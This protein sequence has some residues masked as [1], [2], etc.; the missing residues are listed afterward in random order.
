MSA[1]SPNSLESPPASPSPSPPL[2][3]AP[4][5]R[6]IDHEL[7]S[8]TVPRHVIE[9]FERFDDLYLDSWEKASDRSEPIYIRLEKLMQYWATIAAAASDRARNELER[10]VRDIQTGARPLPTSLEESGA[11]YE[12]LLEE[13]F[14]AFKFFLLWIDMPGEWDKFRA[15]AEEERARREASGEEP[16][17]FP[18]EP[19]L[20]HGTYEKYRHFQKAVDA[21]AVEPMPVVPYPSNERLQA[22]FA[23]LLERL[24][25]HEGNDLPSKLVEG[26][27]A[28]ADAFNTYTADAMPFVCNWERDAIERLWDEEKDRPLPQRKR[29]EYMLL[30]MPNDCEFG[31]IVMPILVLTLNRN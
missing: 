21:Y 28:L 19:V 31:Y 5:Y 1:V 9:R 23:S 29:L 14:A 16:V 13:Q 10:C 4:S 24:V 6:F 2:P 18:R 12:A 22:Q 25:P 3:P 27:K 17:E 26:Q 15:A 30:N 20:D 11:L 7:I 8:E